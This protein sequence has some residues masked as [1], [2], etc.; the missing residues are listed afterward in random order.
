MRNWLVFAL[1]ALA[2]PGLA[3]AQEGDAGVQGDRTVIAVVRDGPSPGWPIQE[4][5]AEQLGRLMPE[6]DIEFRGAPEFDGGWS[7]D[8]VSAALDQA[9]ADT[10]IDFVVVTGAIGTAA[11]NRRELDKPVL[12]SFPQY[13]QVRAQLPI[14]QVETLA[15]SP[16]VT[17]ITPAV[18]AVTN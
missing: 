16:E 10:E 13:K 9:L 5:I 11:A 7:L 6:S 1:I 2:G 15:A 8:G 4:L 3:S 12:S 18:R 17:S 14:A